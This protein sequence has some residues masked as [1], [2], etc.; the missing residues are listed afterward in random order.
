[1]SATC[2]YRKLGDL[3][4]IRRPRDQ[5]Q[6]FQPPAVSVDVEGAAR[7]EFDILLIDDLSRLTRDSLEAEKPIRKLEFSGIRIVSV[8]DGYDSTSKARKIQR[9]FKNLMNETF[10]DDLRERVHRGYEGVARKG[11]WNG[12]RPY[13]Y[14]LRPIVDRTQRDAYGNPLQIGTQLEVEP[15]QAKV[16]Q[17]I[18]RRFVDGASCLV[19][20]KE[21]NARGVPSP[22]SA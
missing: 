2:R 10:L 13:G 14:R 7:K 1:L 18:F 5:R 3:S 19:I 6:R 9:G 17:Q 15:K 8:S 16:V 21:L 12:G 20:A 4:S 22:G 11:Y